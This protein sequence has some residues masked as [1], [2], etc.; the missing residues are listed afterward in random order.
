MAKK[1]NKHKGAH[2]QSKIHPTTETVASVSTPKATISRRTSSIKSQNKDLLFN[3]T[4]YILM[5]A[6]FALVL[7][8]FI[9]MSGGNTDPKV[10]NE[11]EIYSTRRITVAPITIILGFITIVVGILKKPN[12]VTHQETVEA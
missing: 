1:G 2:Q 6:G 11:A 4:N 8:G 10:F 12:T 5:I 3:K 9:L 7:I